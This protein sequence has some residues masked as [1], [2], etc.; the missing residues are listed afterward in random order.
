VERDECVEVGRNKRREAE[1][2]A[3][4]GAVGAMRSAYCALRCARAAFRNPR[5]YMQGEFHVNDED[6]RL[7]CGVLHSFLRRLDCRR[8]RCDV[9]LKIEV[10]EHAKEA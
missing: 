3:P 8:K 7:R 9:T 4:Q 10:G 1:R 5:N 6:K 2:I